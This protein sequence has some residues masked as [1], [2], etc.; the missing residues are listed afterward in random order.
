MDILTASLLILA[1]IGT[2]IAKGIS[3]LYPLIAGLVLF[4]AVCKRRGFE[5]LELLKMAAYGG[6]KSSIVIG[7]FLMI[8]GIIS[9]WMSCGAIP[10]IVYYGILNIDPD[11]FILYAFLLSCVVSFMLGTSFGT[12]GTIGI[13]LSIMA[14]S[15][16]VD[17]TVTTGAVIAGAYFGDRCSFMSSSANLVATITGSDLFSNI[18]SMFSTSAVPFFISA[19]VYFFISKS[20]PLSFSETDLPILVSS[21]FEV[22]FISMLPAILILVFAIFRINVKISML[23]SLVCGILVSVA[24]QDYSIFETMR[25]L[26]WGFE[27][28]PSSPLNS[29]IKGGGIISMAKVSVMVY[30]SSCYS[31]L[32]EGTGILMETQK[33]IESISQ[34]HGRFFSVLATSIIASCLG[35]TQALAIILTQQLVQKLYNDNESK[36]IALD[37][38]NTAVVISPL[39]PWNIAGGAIAQTLG[40]S[41]SYPIYSVYLYIL[42]LYNLLVSSYREKKSKTSSQSA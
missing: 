27:L 12:A 32:F 41:F 40:G 35:F 39:I 17:I 13:V 19:A 4:I 5:L 28:D 22:G 25:F 15:G 7:I 23:L 16:N 38:E 36:E 31:G 37:I 29:I 21:T 30:I 18:K 1:M 34:K 20:N 14:K 24:V 26:V 6:K 10:S 9:I 2:S 3:I 8:G 42:P 11:Y 33:L